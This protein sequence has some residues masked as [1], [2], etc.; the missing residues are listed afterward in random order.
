MSA[1]E[2]KEDP[3]GV[4]GRVALVT[5]ASSGLGRHLAGVLAEAGAR[6]VVTARR[7]DRLD[8]LLAEHDELTLAAVA[9]DVRDRDAIRARYDELEAPF[10]PVEIL[11]NNAGVGVIKPA[12][13]HT[14]DDWDAT[15]DTN[16]RGPF[17][18]SRMLVER[19][20]PEVPVSIVNIASPAASAP[21]KDIS[22]YAASKAA[23]VQLTRVLA[24]EWAGLGVRVNCLAP[25]H[26]ATELNP[27]LADP[28]V[29]SALSRRVPL[30][31]L[32][33]PSD[34]DHA[35]LLLAGTASSYI[36]GAVLP[37]DGGVGLR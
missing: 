34:L 12:L 11:V 6:V 3:W 10:G 7:R 26:V 13:E 33:E 20:R 27:D 23:L 18:L 5:G 9:L 37:V 14:D 19:R 31:R 28:A 21:G 1:H 25:G 32:G 30:G 15:F 35:L 36:T 24:L 8:A 17:Q 4:A 16:V 29:Q 22:A 2:K